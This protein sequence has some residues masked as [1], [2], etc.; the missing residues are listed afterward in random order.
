MGILAILAGGYAVA[1]PGTGLRALAVALAILFAADGISACGTR[2][3]G[4]WD[5]DSRQWRERIRFGTDCAPRPCQNAA[6]H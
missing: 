5:E 1:N 2:R 4:R 3:S 6:H